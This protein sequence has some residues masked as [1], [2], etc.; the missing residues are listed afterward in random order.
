MKNGVTQQT[1]LN[2]VTSRQFFSLAA[3]S[4]TEHQRARKGCARNQKYFP[5]ELESFPVRKD[6]SR[7]KLLV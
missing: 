1:S 4:L 2:L 6:Y 3:P 5:K 7:R